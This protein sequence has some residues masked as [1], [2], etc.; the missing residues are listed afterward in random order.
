M[1]NLELRY[2]DAQ[3][4]CFQIN[5]GQIKKFKKILDQC[6]NSTKTR[7][8]LRIPDYSLQSTAV[9][10]SVQKLHFTPNDYNLSTQSS[11]FAQM[12]DGDFTLSDT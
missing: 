11:K 8:V 9:C 10:T 2:R 7:N 1:L 12:L 5:P 3:D 4:M 6:R